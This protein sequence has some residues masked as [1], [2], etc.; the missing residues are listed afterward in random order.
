MDYPKTNEPLPDNVV[1]ELA[2]LHVSAYA[3]KTERFLKPEE[4]AKKYR[5]ALEI[6]KNS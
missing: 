2:V 5:E 1:H 3:H 6:I 4:I